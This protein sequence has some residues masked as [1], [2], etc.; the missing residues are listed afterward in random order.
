MGWRLWLVW[1]LAGGNEGVSMSIAGC[2]DRGVIIIIIIII[3]HFMLAAY[4]LWQINIHYL[5]V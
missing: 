2:Y 1:G 4:R 5:G 3:F